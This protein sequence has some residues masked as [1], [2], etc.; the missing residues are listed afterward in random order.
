MGH[1]QLL[2]QQLRRAHSIFL[3][4]HDCSLENLYTRVGRS[5]L[6][7]FLEHFWE[8]YAWNW[9]LLLSGNPIVEIYNGVKLAAG[10]ELGIG[11]GEEEWGSGEREVL[12]DFVT[13]TDGLLDL[14]VSRFGEPSEQFGLSPSIP[15]SNNGTW[16]GLDID[17]RP[18]DGV[19]FSG[20]NA[21]SRSSLV[22]VSH[23]ME[24]I[25]RYGD[26][27]Y[28][29]GRDPNSLRRRKPKKQRGR[30]LHGTAKDKNDATSPLTPERSFTPGIPRPLVTAEP[31]AIPEAR[32]SNTPERSN[33][34]STTG[35]DHKTVGSSFGTD[36]VM[37]YL[38]LGYGSSW[39]LSTKSTSSPPNG[40]PAR[41]GEATA[42]D[43]ASNAAQ[44][45]P[46]AG[47]QSTSHRK[48]TSHPTPGHFILGPRDDL[49]TL[50]DLE[51]DSPAS[52]SDTGK[53]KT[54][55]VHRTI[56][57]QLTD[58]P[59][60]SPKRLQAV[61]YVVGL[62]NISLYERVQLA[63]GLLI[64]PTIRLHLLVRSRDTIPVISLALLQHPS[65]IRSPAETS[66]IIYFS[67]D[68]RLT[69]LII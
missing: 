26:A 31:Q 24:W 19:I 67:S 36:T 32:S 56:H 13:R 25:Y 28:G 3:L 15:E 47:A 39:S 7:L 66:A 61:I 50:D 16:L 46:A 27:A 40:S 41:P 54:R 9:E 29:I 57:V 69:H 1:P 2:I 64:A 6:C 34:E 5:S 20:I 51:E 30:Q 55:I 59:D 58:D 33:D 38:T 35:D 60:Q 8:R 65:P 62:E 18:A 44:Q 22:H 11:V 23:W 12:E 17:P 43:H 21:L 68:G 52:E 10:G 49:E 48:E 63:N 14:V 45:S 53:P 4:L 37:R 42:D